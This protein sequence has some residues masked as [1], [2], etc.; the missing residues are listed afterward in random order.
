[1]LLALTSTHA[2]TEQAVVAVVNGREIHQ[3]Q[4]DELLIAQIMPL[5][6]Q[7]Y[8]LRKAALEN[9]VTSTLLEA[10]AAKQ[11]VSL[12]ELRRVLTVGTVTV[13]T[14]DVENEY[15]QNI[16]A[17]GAMSSD[18]AKER[19]RLDL[20]TRARM[21]KYKQAVEALRRT[22]V[23]ELLLQEPRWPWSTL[24]EHSPSLGPKES[25]VT[26]IE[27]AD[28]Q[29]SYCRQSQS[30]LKRLIKD[31]GN[32]VR[33][34]FKHLPLDTHSDANLA[35]RAAFCAGEAG[36]FW[37][38]HDALFTLQSLEKEALRKAAAA[39]KLDLTK[40]DTC[41]NSD[42]SQEAVAKD[43]RAGANWGI[44]STPT[45]VVNGK[46]IPG[47]IDFDTFKSVI[48]QELGFLRNRTSSI[49]S[50]A[51]DVRRQK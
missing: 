44:S 24:A 3:R 30:V 9:L 15:A 11:G 23:V 28:F 1:M 10:E 21:T 22:A 13:K 38:Y 39:L 2:Q 14:E 50:G 47:A 31:Y 29:C 19:L 36:R 25:K 34:I 5:E 46:I 33:L 43:K 45:F 18:E 35:A 4:L 7:L 49:E 37:E 42:R 8:A 17:F 48:E 12:A 6:Q 16:L 32:E 20:E 26:I 40:F 51:P 27:F 41:L